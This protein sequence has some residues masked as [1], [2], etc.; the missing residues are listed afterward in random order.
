MTGMG[1]RLIDDD[2][3][4]DTPVQNDVAP[5]STD[6]GFVH[7]ARGA[8]DGAPAV[9]GHLASIEERSDWAEPRDWDWGALSISE[10]EELASAWEARALDKHASIAAS[11]RFTLQLL[12]WGAPW[13][14]IVRSERAT[15]QLTEHAE[16]CFGVVQSL[17][18]TNVGPGPLPSASLEATSWIETVV[19]QFL[20]VDWEE[21]EEA[22]Q[23][24][25]I[26]L[27]AG[28]PDLCY[29]LERMARES[30]A[31]AE[32]AWR[33]L[34]WA[35]PRDPEW[36][37]GLAQLAAEWR[38]SESERISSVE[39]L[40]QEGWSETYGRVPNSGQEELRRRALAEH[41]LPCLD[42]V[43]RRTAQA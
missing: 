37:A 35:L 16:L 20:D 19:R 28:E 11:A 5:H 41:F 39:V 22:Q 12:E 8:G 18:G 21:T 29:E 26:A 3:L 25:W 33:F 9:R 38:W 10:R 7:H 23:I 13:D 2:F 4:G 32:I 17:R 6:R 15:I 34:V 27:R 36:A 40:S 24:E 14:L 30:R 42:G 31:H 43:A 1:G